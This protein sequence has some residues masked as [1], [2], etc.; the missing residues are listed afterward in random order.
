[1]AVNAKFKVT[2]LRQSLGGGIGV[3]LQPNYQD[4]EGKRINQEWSEATP[5]GRIEMTITNPSA[6][7][8]F[9]LGREFTVTFE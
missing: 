6:S 8:Q 9:A 3:T 7:D 4:A 5:N 2:E 1:M